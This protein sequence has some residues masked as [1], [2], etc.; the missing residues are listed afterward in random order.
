MNQW[1]CVIFSSILINNSS[2]Q[3]L[4]IGCTSGEDTIATRISTKKFT[5]MFAHNYA[6]VLLSV[7]KI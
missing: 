6:H 5:L 3:N 1:K 4:K 2:R 7:N